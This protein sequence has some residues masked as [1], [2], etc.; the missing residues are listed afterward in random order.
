MSVNLNITLENGACT[1]YLPD[2]SK[3]F[4]EVQRVVTP[5]RIYCREGEQGGEDVININY[6][7]NLYR[8]CKN[9][10]CWYSQVN[11]EES[12]RMRDA[13]GGKSTFPAGPSGDLKKG[14]TKR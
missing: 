12:S 4:I 10:N 7:C 11:R 13:N 3:D 1:E 6:G 14:F 9:P 5:L 2:N 8:G